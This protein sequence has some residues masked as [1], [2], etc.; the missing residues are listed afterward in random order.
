MIGTVFGL[1]LL[2]NGDV[3]VEARVETDRGTAIVRY[4]VP[5]GEPYPKCGEQVDIQPEKLN[6][7]I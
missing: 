5:K 6:A 7:G 4:T 2:R 1:F 3:R